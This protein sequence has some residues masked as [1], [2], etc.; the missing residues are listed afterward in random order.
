M[1]QFQSFSEVL[2]AVRRRFVLIA[3]TFVV[4]TAIAVFFALNQPKLYEATAVVQIEEAQ[5]APNPTSATG[6]AESASRRV[7]LIEQRIM[8]RDNL[9]RI[10]QEHGLFVSGPEMPMNERVFRMRESASIQE[11]RATPNVYAPQNQPSGLMIT[12]RL[13]DPQK[14]AGC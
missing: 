5:V 11:I 7:Q 9:V 14:A 1:N 6:A 8:S 2:S 10:M 12:V 13:D 4:G 3:L